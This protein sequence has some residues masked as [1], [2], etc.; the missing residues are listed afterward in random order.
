MDD[1]YWITERHFGDRV[2]LLHNVT[3][4]D[5]ANE[6]TVKYTWKEV[7]DVEM[8]LGALEIQMSGGAERE[9]E[10]DKGEEGENTKG[11][12]EK[13]KG[14]AEKKGEDR[15]RMVKVPRRRSRKK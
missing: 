4:V 12:G 5:G 7:R 2:F 6:P 11:N 8:K 10:T 9:G 13:K 14:N 3:G 15:G 1:V